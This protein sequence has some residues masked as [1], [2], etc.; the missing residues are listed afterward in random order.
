MKRHVQE[1]P[2]Y[3]DVFMG[4]DDVILKH[5]VHAGIDINSLSEDLLMR[6]DQIDHVGLIRNTRMLED[7]E[8]FYDPMIRAGSLLQT[9]GCY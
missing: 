1:K 7:M 3:Q 5:L 4:N 6:F 9:T 8:F 2:Y